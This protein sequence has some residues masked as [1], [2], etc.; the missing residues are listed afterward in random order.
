MAR[1]SVSPIA[2]L[3]FGGLAEARHRAR[4]PIGRPG[5]QLP[6]IDD[7]KAEQ[8]DRLR[9]VAEPGRRLF[10]ADEDGIAAEPRT[11]L[12]GEIADAEDFVAADVDRRG[13]GVAMREA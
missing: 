6:G 10:G 1:C 8:F 3:V 5:D 4:H 11:E 12:C 2:Y 7:R 13:R 9:G